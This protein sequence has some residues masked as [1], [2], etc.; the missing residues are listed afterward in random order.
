MSTPDSAPI[1][2]LIEAFRRSKTM[3][4]AVSM[5]IFDRLYQRPSTAAELA[6]EMG[7]NADALERLLDSCAALQLLNKQSGAYE[8][9]P[10]AWR[11]LCTSS[12]YSLDGYI[13][14]SDEVLYPMWTNLADAV[15]EGTHRWKQSF[16]V[17]GPIFSGFF[18]SEEAMR[19]FLLG[20]HGLGMNISPAVAAALDLSGFHRLADLGGATGHLTISICERY[21]EM[22]G[23]V[24]DLPRVTPLAREMI[25]RSAAR[26]RI[27][28]LDGDFFTDE[29]PPADLYVLGRILHDWT[30]EKCALLL[31]KIY[32]Q[33]PSGGGLLVA[34]K[35]LA[36][37]G[38][39]PISANLQSLNM[40]I[41][42]EGKERTMGEYSLL[43][44]AAGFSSV[45][46]RTTGAWL[47]A[48]LA[49]KR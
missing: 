24:F 2:D 29:L 38:V 35:L 43:L 3:F 8:L 16:G 18:R 26:D 10:L 32:R 11:Y 7:A 6:A 9:T 44:R 30:P 27:E 39:G 21:P 42:T 31:E 14:Y 47:D 33:L 20:M 49:V 34:E 17:D 12:P 45:E 23:I 36:K 41:V 1:I 28:V 4:A 40:L 48:I 19:G 37:D 5:G 22:R 46:G 13:R 25:G 15:K